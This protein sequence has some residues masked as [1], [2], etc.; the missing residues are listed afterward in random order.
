LAPFRGHGFVG[1]V[2]IELGFYRQL[3]S[4]DITLNMECREEPQRAITWS[5][6]LLPSFNTPI[7]S[8]PVY[9]Y[10]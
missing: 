4:S 5:I 8:L 7:L 6:H 9:P 10:L 1:I 2:C 3:A